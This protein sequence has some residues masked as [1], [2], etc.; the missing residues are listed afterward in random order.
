MIGSVS[1]AFSLTTGGVITSRLIYG[2]ANGIVSFF[3]LANIP[4]VDG[5]V[6]LCP[7]NGKGGW[8]CGGLI[9]VC[10]YGAVRI[11]SLCVMESV[12]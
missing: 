4:S 5:G 2:A 8:S 9:R 11:W 12:V 3:S 1:F 10:I 6:L 7:Q